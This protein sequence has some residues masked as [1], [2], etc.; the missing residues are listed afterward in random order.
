MI[1]QEVTNRKEL[2]IILLV[3]FSIIFLLF[4][5]TEKTD[6][7]DLNNYNQENTENELSTVLRQWYVAEYLGKSVEYHEA[8]VKTKEQEIEGERF[9]SETKKN[10]LDQTFQISKEKVISFFSPTELGYYYS[11]WSELFSIYRQPPDIW[12]GISPPFFCISIQHEDFNDT[13]NLIVDNND[14]VVLY[15]NGLFFR[16]EK[17]N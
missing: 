5:C 16:L 8:V 11:D 4:G 15:V 3:L 2:K 12:D 14:N 1:Y 13:L 9:D 6:Q 7:I 17:A 10:Y